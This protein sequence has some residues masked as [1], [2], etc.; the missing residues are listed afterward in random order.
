VTPRRRGLLLV[1][2]AIGSCA[3]A[4]VSACLLPGCIDQGRLE[5]AWESFLNRAD[6]VRKARRTL[7]ELERKHGN[8]PVEH[9][10]AEDRARRALATNAL[11]QLGEAP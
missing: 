8:R 6:P 1:L 5:V 10:P 4:A 2:A 11:R 3:A 9:W 7:E